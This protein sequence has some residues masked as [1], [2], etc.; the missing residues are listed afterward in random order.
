VILAAHPV[1]TS[2]LQNS[3]KIDG[4]TWQSR[5]ILIW[6]PLPTHNGRPERSGLPPRRPAF[7]NPRQDTT[8]LERIARHQASRRNRRNRRDA[9]A[10]MDL[11]LKMIKSRKKIQCNTHQSVHSSAARTAIP[12]HN[13]AIREGIQHEHPP[14]FDQ[15][16]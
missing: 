13:E 2:A 9:A 12:I 14:V 7:G 4:S 11:T 3:E 8:V 15:S 16:K 10:Y 6:R 1:D 5:K